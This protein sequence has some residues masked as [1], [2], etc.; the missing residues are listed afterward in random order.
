MRLPA[1]LVENSAFR[2]LWL[3]R[4][5][6]FAGDGAAAVALV[7]LAADAAGP[8]GVSLL[9]LAQAIPRFFGPV[10]G[11]VVD[12]VEQRRL[13]RVCELGQLGLVAVIAVTL[14]PFPVVLALAAGMSV[15]VTLFTPAGRSSVPALVASDQR[16][17][18]NALL[19]L[20]HNLELALGGLLGGAL[21]AA[22]GVRG[23]L[24]LDA[25]TFAVSAMLLTFVPRLPP[26]EGH[27]AEAFFATVWGGLVYARTAPVVRTLAIAIFVIV[28]LA[29]IDNVALVFVARETL[30]A[31]PDG[32]GILVAG[33]GV[34]MILAAGA[35][36]FRRRPLDPVRLTVIATGLSGIGN[37]ATGLAPNVAAGA[38]AQGVGG[39]GN[40]FQNVATDTL[41]QERVPREM[42]GR[43]FGLIGTAAQ[44][45]Q[46]AAL[47]IAAVALE[48]F[49]PRAVFVVSGAAIL[50]VTGLL[51]RMLSRA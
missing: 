45:G 1:V 18:A 43:V 32:Y 13:M 24:I 47:A 29:G 3:S 39:V 5:I 8:A 40:G 9:L 21:V 10:A 46:V 44:V 7:L 22:V 2:A 31:G 30:G 34:G 27:R 4:V 42:L 35:L 50:V 19:G 23:A 25:A 41:L 16:L 17:S 28:A 49:S 51:G 36:V 38:A 37:L 14:P 48:F 11:A 33:F 6:S 15:L 20:A 26:H 12:R